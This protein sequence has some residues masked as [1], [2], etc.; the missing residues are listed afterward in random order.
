[1]RRNNKSIC[2]VSRYTPRLLINKEEV[3]DSLEF[4]DEHN[5]RDVLM[6][7]DCDDQCQILAEKLGWSVSCQITKLF[8]LL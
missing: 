1:M 5:T 4:H 3:G 7:G 8:K 2:R 6:L